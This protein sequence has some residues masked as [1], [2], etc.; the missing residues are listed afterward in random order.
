MKMEQPEPLKRENAFKYNGEPVK[1]TLGTVVLT[2]ICVLLLIIATFT[3]LSFTH[4]I[5]PT[6]FMNYI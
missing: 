5:I 4:F 1:M 3:Q 6:D 2:C